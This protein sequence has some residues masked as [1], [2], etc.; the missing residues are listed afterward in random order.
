MLLLAAPAASAWADDVDL[1]GVVVSVSDSW[2]AQLFRIVDQLSEWDHASH[3]QYGR[4]AAKAL[5]LDERDRKLLEDDAM[6]RRKRGWGSG[7]EQA[8]LR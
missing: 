1:G 2:T 7:F 6:L 5:N 8:L 3:R 4:W